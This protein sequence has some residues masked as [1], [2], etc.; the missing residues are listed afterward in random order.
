MLELKSKKGSTVSAR[1]AG[2]R[3]H[4]EHDAHEKR[5]RASAVTGTGAR[6]GG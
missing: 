1:I 3:V 5:A 2:I 6:R 4:R